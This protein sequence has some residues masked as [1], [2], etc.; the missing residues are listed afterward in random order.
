MEGWI[1]ELKEFRLP[2]EIAPLVEGGGLEQWR[3]GRRQNAVIL[4]AD[5]RASTALAEKMDPERLSIFISSFRRR[6]MRAAA[7]YGGV[8]DKFM[9]FLAGVSSSEIYAKVLNCKQEQGKLGPEKFADSLEFTDMDESTSAA[10]ALFVDH[11]V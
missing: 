11:L 7:E 8:V 1:A 2:A 10:M 9:T 5:I 4:F 6:V 3:Q